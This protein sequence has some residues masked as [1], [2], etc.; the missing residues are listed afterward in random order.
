MIRKVGL[1]GGIALVAAAILSAAGCVR[2]SAAGAAAAAPAP[3]ARSVAAARVE[4]GSIDETLALAA[5]FRPFQEI[6]VHAKVAG[7]VKEIPVDVGDR[8]KAGQLLAVLEVPEI[9][10][11]IRQDEAAERRS[12]DE[13]HRAAADLQRAE[14]AHEIA[15]LGATRLASVLKDRPKLIAQQDIDEAQARDRMA[16]AQVATA[17]AAV[18]SANEQLAVTQA[19]KNRTR[20]LYGYARL[21]APFAGVITR[22]Y[23]DTGAMI[24]AGTASQTQTMPVVRLSQNSLL[25][26]ALQ[27]PE[28]A[29]PRIHVGAPVDVR[30]ESIGRT[31]PG[32][33]A[34]FADRVNAETRTMET[35]ID[36]SN[37]G[38]ELVPGM[39]ATAAIVLARAS[40]VV[41]APVQAVD[42]DGNTA[43]VLAVTSGNLLEP[44]RVT[45]GLASAD[46]VEITSGLSAGDIVVT[47]SRA[48]LKAG[49]S[50]TPVIAGPTVARRDVAK[51]QEN[52]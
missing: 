50:V 46:R 17:T 1:I 31:F 21:T 4:R 12:Q 20:T 44:R 42:R 25:R 38:L 27:V 14:S 48:G 40:D 2:S 22:R 16:E 15:H 45:V 28:S 8:V 5:E 13:V 18:A 34:R 39:Y 6:D 51:P 10:D 36:V 19:G 29:V 41:I 47:G 49:T 43:T 37:P 30:V 9:E 33:I 35:E 52:R 7:Y 23:A 26:L 3:A 11:E 32:T 24:Q